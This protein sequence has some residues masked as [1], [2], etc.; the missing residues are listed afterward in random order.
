MDEIKEHIQNCDLD[1]LEKNMDTVLAYRDEHGNDAILISYLFEQREIMNILL[2]NLNDKYMVRNNYGYSILHIASMR[3]DKNIIDSDFFKEKKL[4]DVSDWNSIG[5]LLTGKKVSDGFNT[6]GKVIGGLFRF[7]FA[8]AGLGESEP[9]KYERRGEEALEDQR[10]KE[11]FQRKYDEEVNKFTSKYTKAYFEEKK[12]SLET[13]KTDKNKI[14]E[15]KKSREEKDIENRLNRVITEMK[16]ERYEELLSSSEYSAKNAAK[17]E[18]ET[19]DVYQKRL[20]E[21]K[22]IKSEIDKKMTTFEVDYASDIEEKRNEI[23]DSYQEEMDDLKNE[24][25]SINTEL[26]FYD[27]YLFRDNSKNVSYKTVT[28]L[29][30]IEIKSQYDADKQYFD[31]EVVTA[32]KQTLNYKLKVPL[33]I[34]KE[35]K[36]LL[37]DKVIAN[38]VERQNDGSFTRKLWLT[39]NG[40]EYYFE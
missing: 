38:T 33:E 11:E 28:P 36:Q 30:I 35:V 8:L 14:L 39:Y 17:D 10:R 15:L 20:E 37:N 5:S 7:G 34:A 23:K 3:N 18:F 2:K 13:S 31:I 19:T 24:I 25:E 29:K 21:A 26:D 4:H 27:N 22:Q 12:K 32:S 6:A 9:E 1:Y 40:K 16:K